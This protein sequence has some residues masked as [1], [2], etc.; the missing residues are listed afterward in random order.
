MIALAKGVG[1]SLD[2]ASFCLSTRAIVAANQCITFSK[3]IP[4]FLRR[5]ALSFTLLCSA[6]LWSCGFIRNALSWKYP[7]WKI[8]PSDKTKPRL[9]AADYK[10]DTEN[11][12]FGTL[13]GPLPPS[14][15]CIFRL[16]QLRLWTT[17]LHPCRLWVLLPAQLF[18]IILLLYWSP[19]L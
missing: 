11:R 15:S 1:K 9:H 10:L 5:F 8:G 17:C 18:L 6:S 4:S 13:S 7:A 16:W 2:R 19:L 14:G 3:V 12:F